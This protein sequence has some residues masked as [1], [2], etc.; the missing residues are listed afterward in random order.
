MKKLV[1]LLLVAIA[2]FAI[3]PPMA[4]VSANSPSWNHSPVVINGDSELASSDVVLGGNGTE[5]NPYIIANWVINASGSQ[6]GI[7]IRNVR[8]HFVIRNVT[9][10]GSYYGIYLENVS[11]FV[12][13]FSDLGNVTNDGVRVENSSRGLI[14]NNYFHDSGAGVVLTN[15]TGLGASSNIVVSNNTFENIVWYGVLLEKGLHANNTVSGNVMRNMAYGVYL[16]YGPEGNRILNNIIYTVNYSGIALTASHMNVVSENEVFSGRYGI[17]LNENASNNVLVG[18]YLHDTSS[19]GVYMWS[20]G[21]GNRIL[22]NTIFNVTSGGVYL[23][24]TPET[25]IAYNR[26]SLV[27]NRGYGIG[28]GWGN[29]TVIH[30]NSIANATSQGVYVHDTFGG[31]IYGNQITNNGGEGILLVRNVFEMA[32]ENNTLIGNQFGIYLRDNVSNVTVAGNFLDGNLY[33]GISL[34][35]ADKNNVSNNEI[36]NVLRG[37]GVYVWNSTLNVVTGNRIVNTGEDGIQLQFSPGNLLA[38]NYVEHGNISTSQGISVYESPGTVAVNNTVT[39]VNNGIYLFSKS[40]NSRIERNVVYGVGAGVVAIDSVNVSISGNAISDLLRQGLVVQ[41]LTNFTVQ[42][43]RFLNATYN[44]VEVYSSSNGRLLS[45]VFAN[46]SGGSL[47]ADNST[48]LVIAGNR[49]ENTNVGVALRCG[50]HDSIVEDNVMV[51][52]VKGFWLWEVYN[53]TFVNNTVVNSSWTGVY[54]YNSTGNVFYLNVFKNDQNVIADNS[55]AIWHSPQQISYDYVNGTIIVPGSQFTN[56][57]GNYWSDYY[58]SDANGDGVGDV[59]YI[60]DSENRDDYPL[61]FFSNVTVLPPITIEGNEGFSAYDWLISGSGTPN[62]PYVLENFTVN[63]GDRWCGILVKDVSASFVIRNVTVLGGVQGILIQNSTNFVVENNTIKNNVYDAIA[64]QDSG[65]AVIRWNSVDELYSFPFQPTPKTIDGSLEDWGQ[66]SPLATAPD[67]GLPGANLESLYVSW[68]SD[69]LYIA[70]T[71]R[72]NESWDVSYGIAI[73][74]DPYTQFGYIGYREQNDAWNRSIGFDSRYGIDYELYGWWSGGKLTFDN[75]TH[76][77]LQLIKYDVATGSWIYDYQDRFSGYSAAY[78]GDS[79]TGLKTLEVR[80]PW[81]ALGGRQ[82]DIA[83]IAWIAGG[84]G[85]SAVSSV[86]WTGAVSDSSDEWADSDVLSNLAML[87]VGP[88]ASGVHLWNSYNV[89]ISD[90]TLRNVEY[91]VPL[92]NSRSITVVSNSIDRAFRRGVALWG[93]VDS[94]VLKNT[95][96]GIGLGIEGQG[97]LNSVIENNTLVGVVLEGIGLYNS[98]GSV[99]RFNTLGIEKGS[100]IHVSYTKNVSVVDN[101]IS[102]S[103]REGIFLW[104]VNSSLLANNTVFNST[105]SGVYVGRSHDNLFAGNLI[106]GSTNGNGFYV[107]DSPN[108]TFMGN[109]IY[110]TYRDVIYLQYSPNNT[111]ENCYLNHGNSSYYQVITAYLSPGL[112]ILNSTIMGANNGILLIK[113][114]LSVILGNRVFGNGAGV[115]VED[116]FDVVLGGNS[117]AN[118]SRQALVVVNSGNLTIRDSFAVGSGYNAFELY[119]VT[120]A[121]VFRNYFRDNNGAFQ[122][123][124]S[125][126]LHVFDNVMDETAVGV[127]LR[128]G[129]RN[130]LVENNVIANNVKGFWLW[131]VYNNTFVNNTVVNSS[132]TGVYMYN[133]TGNVFYLNRFNNSQNVIMENSTARWYSPEQISYDY[134]NGTIIVPGSQFTNYLGNYWNDYAG[135][136][137]NGDGIGDV[138]YTVDGDSTDEYPLVTPSTPVVFTGVPLVLNN[139]TVTLRGFLVDLGGALTEVWFEYGPVGAN[140][141]LQTEHRFVNSTGPFE[142]QLNG[143]SIGSRYYVR[144]VAKNPVNTSLGN[145][146]IFTV[147]TSNPSLGPVPER[148]LIGGYANATDLLYAVSKGDVDFGYQTY[149]VS[150]IPEDVL[151][152]VSLVPNSLEYFDILFNPV[153]DPGSRY[154][155]TV[156]GTPYFNPFA[157]REIRFAINWLINRDYFIRTA[158]LGMGDEMFTPF[159]DWLDF[160]SKD[161]APIPTILGMS[162]DGNEAKALIMINDAMNAAA[163]EVAEEGHTLELVNGTW[164]FDGRP[165]EVTGLIRVEDER[166]VLGNYLADLLEKAG[167]RVVRKEVTRSEA[168]YLVYST[169]PRSYGWSYYTEG[170]LGSGGGLWTVYFMY[171][172]HGYA[173]ALGGWK[174]S[175]ENTERS[176][177]G[178]VLSAI[179]DGNVTA[180][181]TSLNLQY[182]TGTRLEGILNWTTDEIGALLNNGYVDLDGDGTADVFLSDESQKDDLI[183]LGTALG[184]YESFRV[185]VSRVTNVFPVNPS[186][187]YDYAT[188]PRSGLNGLSIITANTTD[189]TVSVGLYT[190]S[191]YPGSNPLLGV[192]A[193]PN[194]Y[195]SYA[196]YGGGLLRSLVFSNYCS[197]VSA[198]YNVSVPANALVWDDLTNTWKPVGNTS[199]VPV[200]LTLSCTLGTWHD[201]E[202]MTLA[203]YI[204]SMSFAWE[205]TYSQDGFS[206]YPANKYYVGVLDKIKAVEFKQ[207]NDTTV[208]IVMYQNNVPIPGQEL[209]SLALLVPY[210]LAPWQIYYAVEELI[211]KPPYNEHKLDLEGFDQLNP[212]HSQDLLR[213][214][215]SL[216]RTAPIPEYL[217][218]YVSKEEA[219]E[220]YASTSAFI[221]EHGHSLVGNGPFVVEGYDPDASQLRLVAFRNPGYPYTKEY[222]LDQYSGDEVNPIILKANLSSS[223]V[224]VGNS[225]TISFYCTDDHTLRAVNLT[226]VLPNGTSFTTNLGD[227]PGFYSYD[228]TVPYV[229]KYTAVITVVDSSG[230]VGETSLVFYGQRTIVE[231][232]VVTNET[233]NVTVGGGD[234]ELTMDVNESATT[235]ALLTV[236]ATVTADESVLNEEN[237]TSLVVASPSNDTNETALAPVKYI[238][239]SVESNDTTQNVVEKYTL[240]VRYNESELGTIDESTL[241]LYYWNG[242]TWVRVADYVNSTIP[243]GPFV[244]D[245][246]VNTEENYVWAVV[247][248]FSLYVIGGL[249]VPRITITSPENGTVIPAND[250]VNVTVTWV[251]ADKLGIDH[252]EVRVNNGT[253]VNVGLLTSYTLE[254]L[255]FGTYVIEVKAVNVGGISNTTGVVV[256]VV[257]YS[258]ENMRRARIINRFRNKYNHQREL[259]EKLYGEAKELGVPDILLEGPLSLARLAEHD[260]ER[261]IRLGYSVDAL[262]HMIQAYLEIKIATTQLRTLVALYK[263]WG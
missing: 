68:D 33:S 73:D 80:I 244:Y 143:L 72:N 125:S 150:R 228:Y 57:L 122:A 168:S 213:E 43:N 163:Q 66:S 248:H 232:V 236:N 71:T 135:A 126:G 217:G 109:F 156:N 148:V 1:S 184:V 176:T 87:Y 4:F 69:Y 25:E 76:E 8:A 235:G 227:S 204:A 104:N 193:N 41:N 35:R 225:T 259:F 123:D 20:A 99:V 165:V 74:V 30:D 252:Y 65:N 9:V 98:T 138:P 28:V 29:Y 153:H 107:S 93:T 81:E 169:D 262:S 211:R 253:W 187:L 42:S 54:M 241:S 44:G 91:G 89:T 188:S 234:L 2:L 141:T 137:L 92:T 17:Q 34:N 159:A 132:W 207:V 63:A 47:Q 36:H 116:S 129:T 56:Y 158:L 197:P 79:T 229:G 182:Y 13:E 247:N 26:I 161:V 117:F 23:G 152:N 16:R 219:E 254:N 96:S 223:V 220:R 239:V 243:N 105:G 14:V 238:K 167:F 258:R 50:V 224:D 179:G 130:S 124:G 177:V 21:S 222:F 45:N 226:I 95:I 256:N 209:D 231:N 100:A 10:F 58:G 242:S 131:E 78:T 162:P 97:A 113:S 106:N 233:S 192:P 27:N 48:G 214:L 118:N 136:D 108:N 173:P 255:S 203:D 59:P 119:N 155:I 51:G 111:V 160:Y 151:S 18:N 70:L 199:T 190:G 210:P 64:L 90:N 133:S 246:G 77:G 166:N 178:D 82:G 216:A 7:E 139:G 22:N 189:G 206:L 186:R 12:I 140:T 240:K 6:A 49:M 31:T 261:A 46:S 180:G 218:P 195:D 250:T 103:G 172:S 196:T 60:I 263:H 181:A 237:A 5:E 212:Q 84:S 24:Y 32:V 170:W 38:G 205:I 39:K 3:F 67:S 201:G 208:Q 19:F 88:S 128:H 75:G 202:R 144:A 121:S 147:L 53:N 52:N 40:H 198:E 257:K 175:P 114:N 134:V 15:F 61:G 102:Y 157:V 83:I 101:T 221:L 115:A 11:N 154:I 260:Y 194:I 164:Y 185:Y 86:P 127:V 171:S 146:V 142:F 230:N 55:L 120:G 112:R 174:W 62:D 191:Y 37:D 110:N 245:A 149:S 215:E 145:D 200:K 251:G 183:K 85:S 249:S 94:K